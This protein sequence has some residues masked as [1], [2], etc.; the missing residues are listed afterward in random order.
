MKP[1]VPKTEK[2]SSEELNEDAA[3]E[4]DAAPRV[5]RQRYGMPNAL[6]SHWMVHAAR[7]HHGRPVSSYLL[8]VVVTDPESTVSEP[9]NGPKGSLWGAIGTFF[10]GPQ[11]KKGDTPESVSAE[12]TSED[13]DVV[14]G[15]KHEVLSAEVCSLLARCYCSIILVCAKLVCSSCTTKTGGTVPQEDEEEGEVNLNVQM[16]FI[17]AQAEAVRSELVAVKARLD[18]ELELSRLGSIALQS[19]HVPHFLVNVSLVNATA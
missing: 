19:P 11:D 6:S 14:E 16:Q 3:P 8:G 7:M 5:S 15:D 13:A 10:L 12:T 1:T 4:A 18:D 2:D 17:A 9:D